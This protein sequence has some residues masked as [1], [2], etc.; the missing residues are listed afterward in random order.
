MKK[1]KKR[2]KTKRERKIGVISLQSA[3]TL[4]GKIL[5]SKVHFHLADKALKSA[6]SHTNSSSKADFFSSENN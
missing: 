1:K 6:G 3:H 5:A 4:T 2:G